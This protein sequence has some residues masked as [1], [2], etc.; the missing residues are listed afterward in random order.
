MATII[1]EGAMSRLA[2]DE[3]AA[4]TVKVGL[5]HET[6]TA[7]PAADDEF[8][9]DL[10]PA[11]NELVNDDYARVTLAGKA[12]NLVAGVWELV[13]DDVTFGVLTG[14]TLTQG[15]SGWFLY[16]HVGADSANW[17]IATRTFADVTLNGTEVVLPWPDGVVLTAG[18]A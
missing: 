12:S 10:I 5:L 7:A 6:S 9:S 8:V 15:V 3:W 17:L 18:P 13:A 16:A 14:A 1:H 11:S 4:L 2:P